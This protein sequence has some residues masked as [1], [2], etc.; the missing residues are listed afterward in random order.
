M[1]LA[2]FDSILL[3]AFGGPT[4]PEEIRPFLDDVLRGRPVPAERYESVVQHYIEVGGAS[5]L[6]RLTEEQAEGLRARL[7]S[8]GPDLPV[9][10]GMRHWTPR[11]A[12]TLATMAAAGRRRAVGIV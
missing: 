2:P 12:E 6:N 8:D 3:L 11:I 9:Y 1:S 5:P 7:R 10:V 4:R